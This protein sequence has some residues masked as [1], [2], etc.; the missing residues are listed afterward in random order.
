MLERHPRLCLLA[1]ITMMF[2]MARWST[3]QTTFGSVVGT[4]NDPS[5]SPVAQAQVVLTNAGTGEAHTQ[6]TSADGLY[7]FVN[8][9]PGHYRVEVKKSGFRGETRSQVTVETAS[10]VRIDFALQVGELSQ[11]V[12]VT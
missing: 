8:L 2:L 4:V 11:T 7:Q 5:G 12:E 10:T 3:A 1:A 9:T 6:S